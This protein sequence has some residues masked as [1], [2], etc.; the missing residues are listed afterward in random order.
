MADGLRPILAKIKLKA[1]GLKNKF[2]EQQ[3]K[4][5]NQDLCRVQKAIY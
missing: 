1:L 5:T 3:Y 2:N 4:K